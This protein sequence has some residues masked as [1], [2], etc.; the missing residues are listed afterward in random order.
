MNF[1][2]HHQN[3]LFNSLLRQGVDLRV[4]YYEQVT[5]H[6]I[7]LGW[8]TEKASGDWECALAEL[9][10]SARQRL[11]D[12]RD[13]IHIIPGYSTKTLRELAITASSHGISW[14]HWSECSR[15]GLRRWLRYPTKKWYA[16]L[17]NRHGLGAFAQGVLARLDFMR[18]GISP[19]KIADLTY[20]VLPPRTDIE[21]DPRIVEFAAGRGVFLF[22]G[23]MNRRKAIDVQLRAFAKLDTDSWCLVMVGSGD[24]A[25]YQAMAKQWSLS[26]KVLFLPAVNWD[27]VGSVHKAADV[28]MLPSRYDGWGVVASE[29]VAQAKALIMSTSCGAAWHLVQ[30]GINGF[31]VKPGSVDSL[32]SALRYY[33]AGGRALALSHGKQSAEINRDYSCDAS[34]ARMINALHSWSCADQN[35]VPS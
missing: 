25:K 32:A 11:L 9:G 6:R 3:G 27:Q 21:P 18:W 34:A 17:L 2:S 28:L 35:Q 4:T 31:L 14:C 20:S 7:A 19:D 24:T 10:I 5:Q 30:P 23:Q 15:P 8:S 1:K 33:V 13:Y 16:R 26:G 22:L 12:L 29:A